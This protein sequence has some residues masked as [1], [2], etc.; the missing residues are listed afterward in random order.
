MGWNPANWSIV[1]TLQGQSNNP[2]KPAPKSKP[3]PVQQHNS[4]VDAQNKKGVPAELPYWEETSYGV[5]RSSGYAAAAPVGDPNLVA[6]YQN[7][8]QALTNQLG[9][10]DATQNV[11][12]GNLQNSYRSADNRL[13]S[14]W[15]VAQRDY[16]TGKQ[17]TEAGYQSARN[18]A[19]TQARN[20]L[21][22]LQRLLGISGAGNSSAAQ[23]AVPLAVAQDA[24]QKIAPVQGTYASNR[25]N[26]DV[27]FQDTE[28]NYKNNQQDLVQKL[29]S[30]E[31]ALKQ[32]IAQTRQGLLAQIQQANI[33]KA[34]AG[35]A[36]YAQ[37]AAAQ[38]GIT[39]QINS[40]LSQITQLGNQY[41]NPVLST[42]QVQYKAPEL[43]EYLM[44]QTAGISQ[45]GLP[46]SDSVNPLFVPLLGREEDKN[47]VGA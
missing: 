28:R 42:G 4:W 23:Q 9:Q 38:G 20:K 6:Q 7:Q 46:G 40:L 24:T 33:Q 37:A 36:N 41:A 17:D 47:I 35:G 43:G 10:L 5:P 12:L 8:A 13:N 31:Q 22:A 27:N 11:G 45:S 25:R 34:V 21:S 44:G 14:E 32:Q 1:N 29:F 2:G 30:Q 26:Q 16:T 3:S 39:N 18:A 19:A 15:G